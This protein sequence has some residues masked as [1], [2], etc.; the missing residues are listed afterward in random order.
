[1]KNV[2]AARFRYRYGWA[3][4]QARKR[5]ASLFFIPFY[6]R[7]AEEKKKTHSELEHVS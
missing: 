1:M 4:F 2:C 7:T 5:F 3:Y 6:R